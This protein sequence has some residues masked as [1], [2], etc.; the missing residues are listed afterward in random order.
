MINEYNKT[1]IYTQF[2]LI[3]RNW[4]LTCIKLVLNY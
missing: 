4:K 2:D 1:T 3:K